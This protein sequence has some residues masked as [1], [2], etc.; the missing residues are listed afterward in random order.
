M[1]NCDSAL[2]REDLSRI[3]AG[4]VLSGSVSCFDEVNRLSP[5]VLS[6]VSVDIENIQTGIELSVSK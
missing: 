3:L 4:I 2:A 1:F 6:A 5:S